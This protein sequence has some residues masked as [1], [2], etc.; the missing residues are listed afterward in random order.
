MKRNP[1]KRK[2]ALGHLVDWAAIH[3][4]WFACALTEPKL[5]AAG[6]PQDDWV[7]AQ[8]YGDYR[9]QEIVDLWVSLN[10][11]LIHV[12]AQ[13]PEDKLNL[14]CRIGFEEP[15]P[16]SKLIERYVEYCEDMVGQMLAHL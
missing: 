10:R 11:L 13:I 3:Q 2:E 16:L 9:W 4:V 14:S 1:W 7:S 6:Y 5:V 15:I 12:L 8:Q